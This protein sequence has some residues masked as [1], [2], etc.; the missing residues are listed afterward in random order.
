MENNQRK[1]PCK[2]C[3]DRAV[4]CH[5]ICEEYIAFDKGRKE[6]IENR[7]RKN[8]LYAHKRELIT[9]RIKRYGRK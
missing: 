8:E 5:S 7:N 6:F 9:K 1:P 4:G 3:P 2:N